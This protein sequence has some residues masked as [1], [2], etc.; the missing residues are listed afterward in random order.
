[1]KYPPSTWCTWGQASFWALKVLSH[2]SSSSF[3]LAGRYLLRSLFF[4]SVYWQRHAQSCYRIPT[5]TKWDTKDCPKAFQKVAAAHRPTAYLAPIYDQESGW[6]SFDVCTDPCKRQADCVFTPQNVVFIWPLLWFY[7]PSPTS[8]NAFKNVKNEN[9]KN[10]FI[11]DSLKSPTH[12][13]K[14]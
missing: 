14:C 7:A 5:R 1:M 6:I 8:C 9:E 11:N 2:G 10:I 4:H 13:W 3:P 12:V